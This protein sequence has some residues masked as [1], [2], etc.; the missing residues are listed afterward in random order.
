MCKSFILLGV[1]TTLTLSCTHNKVSSSNYVRPDDSLYTL[2]LAYDIYAEDPARALAVLDS[3]QKLGNTSAFSADK[4]RAIILARNSVDPQEEKALQICMDLLQ[5]D[6]TQVTSKDGADHRL[7]ILRVT[8][9]IFR[10]RRDYEN[11]LKYAIDV[12]DLSHEMGMENEAI[13]TEAEIGMVLTHLGR[14]AEGL[15]KLN[16]ALEALAPR[17]TSS[18]DALDAWV[19]VAKRNINVYDELDRPTEIIGLAQGIIDKLNYFQ[20]NA[21]SFAEDSDRLPPSA[22]AHAGWCNF[23]RAQAHGFLARAYALLGRTKE[24]K[25]EIAIFEATDHGRSFSGKRMI[26][27]AWK[28]VGYWDKVLEFDKILEQ[29]MGT[30]TLNA[31]YA[32]ILRD[33]SD[34]AKSKGHYHEALTWLDRHARVQD[35]LAQQLQSS[36]AQEY[37]SKYHAKEQELEIQKAR[38]D[39]R[40]KTSALI[41]V[42]IVFILAGL[43]SMY[44]RTQRRLISEKNHVLVKLINRFAP[45]QKQVVSAKTEEDGVVEVTEQD[46]ELFK[47]IDEAIRNERL[48]ANVSLQRQDILDRFNMRRQV[49]NKLMAAFAGGDSFPSYVNSIRLE[50]AV[51]LLRDEPDRPIGDIAETVG[52]TMANFRVAFKQ[53]YGITPAEFRSNL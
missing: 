26:T 29:R 4:A 20:L 23:Y 14:E 2:D 32:I 1:L 42:L 33:R 35:Q 22:D 7:D 13:R 27:G 11:W 31:E 51:R 45:P 49:L 6:S 18:V 10:T 41:A 38:S 30:D 8:A 43:A 34:A 46:R 53:S 15:K 40:K 48:Y 19:V 16:D 25:R 39:A 5:S 47:A 17:T 50:E 21:N 36:Q 24:A 28:L 12:A 44:Y 37:A 52:F 3:A 9:E